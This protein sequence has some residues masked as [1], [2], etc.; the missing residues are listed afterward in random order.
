[1]SEMLLETCT[2]AVTDYTAL[3]LTK[4]SYKFQC[5]ILPPLRSNIIFIGMNETSVKLNVMSDVSN[6]SG[7]S[8][9]FENITFP[10]SSTGV[11][12]SGVNFA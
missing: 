5:P 4:S 12:V 6:I 1:M 11:A 7:C 10:E 3:F 9:H 8:F 2:P